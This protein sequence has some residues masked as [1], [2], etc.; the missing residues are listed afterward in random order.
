[1]NKKGIVMMEVM[2]SIVLFAI[3]GLV[4]LDNYIGNISLLSKIKQEMNCF[5]LA[6]QEVFVYQKDHSNFTNEGYFNPPYDNFYYQTRT[7]DVTLSES[8]LANTSDNTVSDTTLVDTQAQTQE[9]N[10]IKN[11]KIV[12]MT[13]S[14]NNSSLTVPIGIKKQKKK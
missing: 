8:S 7:E 11:L 10:K 13:I 6:Q 3:L 4:C 12:L 2:I 5:I 1:M 14:G 9:I